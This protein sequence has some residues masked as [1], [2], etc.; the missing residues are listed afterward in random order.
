MNVALRLTKEDL[1]SSGLPIY[2]SLYQHI[3]TMIVSG[4]LEAGHKLPP[5]RLL[6]AD[7]SIS[8]NTVNQAYEA[9]VADGFLQVQQGAGYFV[10]R[11]LNFDLLNVDHEDRSVSTAQ[12]PLSSKAQTWLSAAGFRHSSPSNGPFSLS[13]PDVDGFP[14][15][16]WARLLSR[17]WRLHG[18][19]MVFENDPMGYE[20]LRQ[21]V[22]DY[23]RRS[24]G[25]KCSAHQVLIVSGAQQGI[26]LCGRVLWDEGDAVVL[27]D[28]CFPG[29]RGV[30]QGAGV[31]V[32][33]Q[34]IDQEGMILEDVEERSSLRSF[35]VTPSR[36]Y[37]LGTTMSL[38]RRIQLLHLARKR[39]AWIIE[40]DFDSDFHF[41]GP[42]LSALQG[43]DDDERVFYIGSFSRVI[44]PALRLGFVVVP[45]SLVQVFQAVK[46][47]SDGHT[48]IVHQA[49]LADFMIEGFFDA[50][51]RRMKKLYSKR[52]EVMHHVLQQRFKGIFELLPGDG[53]LHTCVKLLRFHSDEALAQEVLRETGIVLLPLSRFYKIE[54]K[55]QGFVLPFA[56]L[57]EVE[58]TKSLEK[59]ADFM[60]Q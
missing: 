40:D 41:D 38:Q 26:D 28:P 36:N 60:K 44:F 34:P 21:Q 58:I 22:A 54:P 31:D 5:S 49:A 45:S 19:Q 24:R 16:D 50:H 51:I 29:A 55:M 53:G 2:R 1:V 37:P 42:P 27:E 20:P 46:S 11:Q 7:L 57:S 43:L 15:A 39:Q 52:R 35:F 59:L 56:N 23:L 17:R 25:V 6:A 30:L 9:L 48:S 8:R 32:I 10:E 18:K 47:F 33:S 12:P 3:R 14:Y 4:E 13:G